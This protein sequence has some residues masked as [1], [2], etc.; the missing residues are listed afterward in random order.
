MR[1]SEWVAIARR[2]AKSWRT[3]VC[4]SC[5]AETLTGG[6]MAF[7]SNCE[8]I[9][10]SEAKTVGQDP[11]LFVS[12]GAIRAAV[13]RK[14]FE[15]A[16]EIYDQMMKGRRSPQLLYAKGIMYV[17]FSNYVI[18]KVSYDGN[19]MSRNVELRERGAMLASESKKLIAESLG[20]SEKEA[21][22]VPDAHIFYRM[23]LCALKL[24]DLRA[25]REY[26]GR[27][28]WFDKDG[29]IASY[30]KIVLNVQGGLYK[31]AEMGLD[32]LV[33]TKAMIPTANAFYYAA[34][35]A[36]KTGDK[37]GAER[38]INAS[39]GLIEGQKRT[40]ILEAI[41]SSR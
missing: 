16:A 12:V 11:A 3:V 34:L 5:G 9:V 32:K 1:I 20:I 29:T 4:E 36:F 2:G 19:G 13:L 38:L 18:S 31:E 23:F 35:V 8:S 28:S 33:K 25:A 17:E 24:G 40:N 39:E 15:S 30:A 26:S 37:R 27:I 41:K 10:G 22:D 14:D 7:C 21:K 6:G